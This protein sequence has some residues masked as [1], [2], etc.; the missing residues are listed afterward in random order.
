MYGYGFS[1][2]FNSATAA[3]KAV[4]DALFNRLTEDGVNRVMEDNQQRIIE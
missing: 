4:A 1:M 3:I 2:M